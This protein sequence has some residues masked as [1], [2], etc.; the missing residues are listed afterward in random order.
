[1]K[2]IMLYQMDSLYRESMQII[3]YEFGEGEEALCVVGSMRGNEVQ[4]LYI[5]SR[6]IQ[7]L[8]EMEEKEQLAA[9]KKILIIPC[10]NFYSMNIGRRFWPTDYSDINRMFPGYDKGETTQRIADGI[11]EKIKNY[12]FGVQFASF[13]MRGNFLPH[14]RIMKTGFEDVE[15][16]KRFGFPYVVLRK[17]RPFD[18]TT[19]NYNWQ[20]WGVKGFSIYTTTTEQID[21]NSAQEAVEGI[22]RLMWAEGISTY[23][24][25][26]KRVYMSRVLDDSNLTTVRC[27][28]AGIYEQKVKVGDKVEKGQVLAKILHPYE[29]EVLEELLAPVDGQIFFLH[30]DPLVY[31]DTAVGK[32]VNFYE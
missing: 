26:G 28:M 18:T 22:L 10:L 24:P 20:L 19:L 14:I 1:M 6:L 11:F 17:P 7:W 3:G 32:I 4:Q 15:V 23:K 8:K 16:A 29:G 25:M 21:R 9:G 27:Q 12:Q 5:C 2:K 13:Y 31:E 30:S